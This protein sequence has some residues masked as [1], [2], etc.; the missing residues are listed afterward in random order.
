[1]QE[2]SICYVI[3]NLSLGETVLRVDILYILSPGR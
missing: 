2:I 3:E 1:M